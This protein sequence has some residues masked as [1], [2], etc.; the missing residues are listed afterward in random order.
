MI[1]WEC[2]WVMFCSVFDCKGMRMEVGISE[3]L[4]EGEWFV[5]VDSGRFFR[6][7]W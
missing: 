4:M 2:E 7:L 1:G 5:E 3:D 6:K